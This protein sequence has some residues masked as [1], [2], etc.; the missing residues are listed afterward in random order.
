[1][2]PLA[3]RRKTNDKYVCGSSKFAIQVIKLNG[4]YGNNYNHYFFDY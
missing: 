2:L 3:L 4:D 1:M